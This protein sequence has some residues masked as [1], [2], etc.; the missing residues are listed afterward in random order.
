MNEE[1]EVKKVACVYHSADLDG[2]CSAAIVLGQY[3]DCKLVGANYG[4]DEHVE[5]ELEGYDLVFFVDY[6]LQPIS[7]MVA[8]S[9]RTK[10][11]WLDHHESAVKAAE[12]VGYNPDGTRVVGKAGCELVWEWF[13]PGERMPEAVK[14]LGVYDTWRM[15]DMLGGERWLPVAG[16]EGLYEVSTLGRV[17]SLSRPY[18]NQAGECGAMQ[19]EKIMQP[20]LNGAGYPQVSLWRGGVLR[21]QQIHRLVAQAFLVPTGG[22]E[23]NHLDGDRQNNAAENLEWCTRAE[24]MAHAKKLGWGSSGYYGVGYRKSRGLWIA[25]VMVRGV[26]HHIGEYQEEQE[27]AEA[28]DLWVT[29]EGLE[30]DL[31]LNFGRSGAK[32]RE[33]VFWK[34]LVLPFQYGMRTAPNDPDSAIWPCL[35]GLVEETPVKQLVQDLVQDGKAVLLYVAQQNAIAMWASFEMEHWGYNCLVVNRGGA[36]SQL[37]E[38]KWDPERHDIMVAFYFSRDLW[39]VYLYTDK[40]G[41]DV[42]KIAFA[43]GGGGH[44]RAAGFTCKELP[45]VL[46]G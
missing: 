7:R 2:K 26:R 12:G 43:H 8:L 46:P 6:G 29:Q 42:S 13:Y 22:E 5:G 38:S 9:E 19:P 39:K 44:K 30:H 18:K 23:V 31:P 32:K 37:F 1:S 20:S 40:E 17:K 15:S 34:Q 4:H 21:A 41:V 36:N 33:S 3:P 14:L 27:A 45:F 10:V 16:Y 35:F 25:R 24:N 11:V 28:Y